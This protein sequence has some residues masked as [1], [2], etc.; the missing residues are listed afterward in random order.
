M[1]EVFVVSSGRAGIFY[2]V[3]VVWKKNSKNVTILTNK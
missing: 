2:V 1:M 3:I